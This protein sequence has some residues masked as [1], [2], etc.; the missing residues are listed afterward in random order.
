MEDK[1][2]ILKRGTHYWCKCESCGWEDTSMHVDGGHQIADTG[3]Y[4]D[5]YCP[6][7][8]C[9]ELEGES[10]YITEETYEDQLIEIPLRELLTPYLDAIRKLR[11]KNLSLFCELNEYKNKF[12]G[13]E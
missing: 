8:G 12:G 9:S 11:D 4:G 1:V 2:I 10:K 13:L 7:C 5:I 3:D 6:I